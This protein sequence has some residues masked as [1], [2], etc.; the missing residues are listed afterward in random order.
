[1]IGTVISH[2]RILEKLGEGGMG[3]VYKALDTTLGRTVALKFVSASAAGDESMKQRLVREAKACAALNHPNITTVYEYVQSEEHEFIAIEFIEGKTLNQLLES[4]QFQLVESFS[5]ALQLLDGLEA[6]HRKGVIHRDLKASNIM[7]EADGRVKIMDFGLAKLTQGSMLTQPGSTVG[8]AA[9]MSP[10][11]ARGEETDHRTDIY[12]LGVVLYQLLTGK[13]PFDNPH[14]LAVL[15]AVVNVDPRPLRELDPAIPAELENIVLKAMAKDPDRRFQSC[16][17][18]ARSLLEVSEAIGGANSM[19]RQY[20]HLVG[21]GSGVSIEA[22]AVKNAQWIPR[23]VILRYGV[24]GLLVVLAIAYA[25]VRMLPSQQDNVS[26]ARKL[27]KVHVDSAL[28]LMKENNSAMA[29]QELQS[30]VRAD[31]TYGSAWANLAVL[32]IRGKRLDLAVQQ[33]RKAVALDRKNSSPACYNLAYAFEEIG[34][35][36]EALAWYS[37]A[38]MTDSTLTPAYSALANLYVKSDRPEEAIR[39]L[40]RFERLNPDL[41]MRWLLDRSYG[42]A[43]LALH[44]YARAKEV[45][46]ESQQLQ[47]N[48]PETLFL[49]ASAYEALKMT[50]ESIAKWQEYGKTEKDPAKLAEALLHIERLRKKSR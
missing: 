33:C 31:S 48:E 49:L 17:V 8:T 29:L 39:L 1:M 13:L 18:M 22:G 47:P 28:A 25:I 6:A 12:S 14:Y 40:V 7:L 44:N 16:A 10:E 27:A 21:S 46:E 23:S 41:P 3:V 4:K 36:E 42:K 15:Y 19:R 37:E 11:Q 9:Y 30:A 20:R 45:L 2:Y 5:I 43:H 35:N 50:K 34:N 26:E 38:I 24:P 32:N